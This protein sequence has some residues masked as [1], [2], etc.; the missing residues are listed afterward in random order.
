MKRNS[1]KKTNVKRIID[2]TYRRSNKEA[3]KIDQVQLDNELNTLFVHSPGC[4]AGTVQMWFRAGSA[5]EQKDNQGIAHFLEHMFFK[6]TPKRPGPQLAHDIESYGGEVNAFTSF[7]YTCYYI[8]T[9]S[10]F[11]DKSVDILLDMVANPLFSSEDIP[12]E[13][14]VV[15]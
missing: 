14:Q 5:L 9:P 6:G 4:S 12:A 13:R 1:F 3:M 7:D 8:N 2:S 15:F 10:L 11:M